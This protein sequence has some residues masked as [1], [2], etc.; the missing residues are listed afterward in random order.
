M[1]LQVYEDEFGKISS[2]Y[3]S[4]NVLASKYDPESKKLVII[5]H[6]GNQYL[7][8]NVTKMTF[9]HFQNAK[10]Q[11]KEIHGII[12]K[13]HTTKLGTIDPTNIREDILNLK[14]EQK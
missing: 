10:S 13:H 5:F 4:S 14:K 7:Y 2:L 11:G 8:E 1:V 9:N 6:N 3:D 12:K